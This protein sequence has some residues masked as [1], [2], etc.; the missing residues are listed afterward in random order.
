[1]RLRAGR[2][3]DLA[4]LAAHLLDELPGRGAL[5]LCSALAVG[6]AR[7]LRASRRRRR[8]CRCRCRC[9]CR[10]VAVGVDV[11]IAITLEHA[12]LFSVQGHDGALFGWRG[13]RTEQG[14]RDSN[15]QPPVLET[16][17]LPVELLPS[18]TRAPARAANGHLRQKRTRGSAHHQATARDARRTHPVRRRTD[19]P[20]GLSS[21][22]RARGRDRRRARWRPPTPAAVAAARPPR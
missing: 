20:I 10:A 8:R 15:P 14:R 2:P 22:R 16:V 19:A 11:E 17:A 9:R 6:V 21:A 13:E 1:M 18:G 12:L 7:P 3:G 4:Q 5:A